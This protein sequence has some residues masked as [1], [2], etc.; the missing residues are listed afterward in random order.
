MLFAMPPAMRT[1]T[2]ALALAAV[3]AHPV[4]AGQYQVT[5]GDLPAAVVSDAPSYSDLMDEDTDFGGD[6]A[7]ALGDDPLGLGGERP[8]SSS[9]ILAKRAAPRTSPTPQRP[10][11]V[12][13]GLL[14]LARTA[15]APSSPTPE[16]KAALQ[17]DWGIAGEDDVKGAWKQFGSEPSSDPEA[18]RIAN[19]AVRWVLASRKAP[20]GSNATAPAQLNPG[21]TRAALKLAL[22]ARTRPWGSTTGIVLPAGTQVDLVPLA[23]GAWYRTPEGTWLPGIWL[24]FR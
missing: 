19:A 20:A 3:L 8:A 16:F 6:W 13:A 23:H 18:L 10:T 5:I 15:P 9:A 17:K 4:R 14:K 7:S 24:E 22:A 11:A 21:A 12:G 1:L 2:V